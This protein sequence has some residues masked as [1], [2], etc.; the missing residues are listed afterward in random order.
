MQIET[1]LLTTTLRAKEVLKVMVFDADGVAQL[2]TDCQSRFKA[3]ITWTIDAT[4]VGQI[5]REAREPLVLLFKRFAAA[6]GKKIMVGAS[7]P[8]VKS[9]FQIAAM[10]A[11]VTLVCYNDMGLIAQALDTAKR[12]P[13]P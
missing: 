10:N 8:F 4:K 7:Q 6:K 11:N 3:D 13:S 1:N 12:K 5:S 2:A 9:A